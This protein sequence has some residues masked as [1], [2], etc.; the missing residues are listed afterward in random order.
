MYIPTT[1]PKPGG[2][3][4]GSAAAKDPNITIVNVEDILFFP[5]RDSKGILHLGD[6]VMKDNARM[7]QYYATKSKISSPYESDGDED[8]INI[9]QSIE[10]Q[11][12]GNK[13]EIRE[14]IQNWLGKNVI[15]FTGSCS[16][17]E[18]EVIGTKCAPLQLRPSKQ[19]N[20]DGRF[21]MLKWEAFATSQFLP[22]MYTGNLALAAPYA[23]AAVDAVP[24]LKANGGQYKLPALAVTDVIE[25]DGIDLD[26][27]QNVALIGGGGVA[28]ATLASAVSGDV[29]VILAGGT[30]WVGLAGAV[31]NL[32]VFIA[33]GTTYLIE[34]SRS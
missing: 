11:H 26:H 34:R 21:H 19:D 27:G 18:L 30:T 32:E 1:V 29:T 5:P 9:K 22:G 28:P 25:V 10:T 6:F 20:N 3:S 13:K 23:V 24:L 31:I 12:P 4:P 7:I 2:I 15:V 16:E 14:L 8:S 33:G 17:P